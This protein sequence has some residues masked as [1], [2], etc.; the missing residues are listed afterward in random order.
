MPTSKETRQ[1]RHE[2]ADAPRTKRGTPHP[3]SGKMGDQSFT[4]VPGKGLVHLVKGELGWN[5]MSIST[6]DFS[7][8]RPSSTVIS[9]GRAIV[10]TESSS[11][12]LE[13]IIDSAAT[14]GNGGQYGTLPS[15]HVNL[16]YDGGGGNTEATLYNVKSGNA[17]LTIEDDEDGSGNSF[18][19]FTALDQ[20]VSLH[21][22]D[23][24][25]TY[26]SGNENK[27][28]AAADGADG[29]AFVDT[30]NTTWTAVA[31]AVSGAYVNKAK[32]SLVTLNDNTT[33]TTNAS[34]VSGGANFNLLAANP[35]STDALKF[36]GAGAT[37]VTRT[38]ASTITITS[39]D[40]ND[41]YYLTGVSKSGNQLTFAVSGATDPTYT[42]GSNAF[43]S[44]SFISSGIYL[45]EAYETDAVT[46]TATASGADKLRF[47][48]TDDIN[49]AISGPSS[50]IIT[51][52]P[53]IN[54]PTMYTHPTT[55]GNKH[56]PSGGAAN[57]FLEYSSSG[58]AVWA[59][60]AGGDLPSA[61]G[62]NTSYLTSI[63]PSAA[64]GTNLESMVDDGGSG[65]VYSIKGGNNITVSIEG[66]ESA[67]YLQIAS[68]VDTSTFLTNGIVIIEDWNGSEV[69]ETASASGGDKL[70]FV[71]NDGIEWS[72][73]GPTLN[74][75]SVTPSLSGYNSTNW[76][77]A[78]THSQATHAPTG[79]EVNVQSDWN[80]VSGDAHILNKPTLPTRDSLGID[81]NDA[82]TFAALT[83]STLNTGQGAT[84]V[85]LMNQN[86]KTDSDIQFDSFGV[87]TAASGVTGEIRAINEVTAYY[88][89]DRLKNRYGNIEKALEKVCSL[90]GFHYQPNEVA[91]QLGYDTSQKKVGVSA[92][93]VLKV[94][95]EAVTEAP[96]DPQYH[97]VQYDK[98]IPLMIEAIKELSE[99]KC[100]CGV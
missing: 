93:E 70:R 92:Q 41:N 49:W 15:G 69:E 30:A 1:A 3:R 65:R 95:P 16:I 24:V 13:K 60:I 73:S 44:T 66:S 48:E 62:A 34:T 35:T 8:G 56:I 26:N 67:D 85:Y 9:S 36:A 88:S 82:V 25:Y 20:S 61:C 45:I 46:T 5:E 51:I 68:T 11:S 83:C 84:E 96:I 38:D 50:D 6:G 37:T 54:F 21:R 23:T 59:T 7:R 74:V 39:T 72:I 58:T 2:H 55:A 19:L 71:E 94:L 29:I 43:N 75:I 14:P 81:T 98:L 97:A 28:T 64:S 12:S 78:H 90:N 89:D 63:V 87:G 27:D 57:Q 99:R 80:S 86:V 32:V 31:P 33:Y 53:T 18:L 79:A 52:T 91:G 17:N 76:D 100:S 22:F 42:F 10:G 4:Q 47:I 40:A 77:N